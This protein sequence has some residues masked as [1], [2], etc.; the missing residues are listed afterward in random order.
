[1]LR[2]L[3]SK[4]ASKGLEIY[5]VSLDADEHFW[6]TSAVNLPWICVRDGDGVYST[7]VALYN[8]KQ[9]P[10]IFLINRNNELRM[11]GDEIKDLDAAVKSL[12]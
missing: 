3:Y 10:A 1:M 9:V 8:V 7:N 6:K 11:R 12:L 5:Q 2:D 4:Y